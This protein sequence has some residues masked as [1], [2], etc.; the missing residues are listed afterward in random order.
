MRSLTLR[1]VVC[2]PQQVKLNVKCPVLLAYICY[3]AYI[4][5]TTFDLNS[6]DF[7][8]FLENE[9]QANKETQKHY[10]NFAEMCCTQSNLMVFMKYT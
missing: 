3:S 8:Y 7:H 5:H 6:F 4:V 9:K 2:L 10:Q 1:N